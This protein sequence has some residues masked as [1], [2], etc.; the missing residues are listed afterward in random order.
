MSSTTVP[1][2]S[3]SPVSISKCTLSLDG[4]DMSIVYMTANGNH[5]RFL[6]L[7][8]HPIDVWMD[9]LQAPFHFVPSG[10]GA[11][12]TVKEEAKSDGLF[13]IF[14]RLES[15]VTIHPLTNV[16]KVNY[17]VDLTQYLLYYATMLSKS[18]DT[19][20]ILIANSVTAP[21]LKKMVSHLEHVKVYTPN[22]NPSS[23]VKKDGSIVYVK[24]FI[25][26]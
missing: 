22:S 15:A 13:Q 14:S 20:L 4:H 5:C 17:E 6:N 18:A 19:P 7:C 12:C 8:T 3:T 21:A 10:F 1:P 23:A 2:G 9:S 11:M 26:H 16:G 25:A 24:G